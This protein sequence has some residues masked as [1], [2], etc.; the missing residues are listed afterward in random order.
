MVISHL[1]ILIGWVAMLLGVFSGAAIGLFFHVDDWAGGYTSF[2]R[3][4][5]R[6]GH[7]SFFGLGFINLLFGLTLQSISI[8]SPYVNIASLGFMLGMVTMP[9]CCY[10]T[11]WKRPFRHLF[12]VPVVGVATAIIGLLMGWYAT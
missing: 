11:A 4:M 7:I 10:L 8:R 9:L 6:L 5:L 3:R 2:R 12:P 1:H